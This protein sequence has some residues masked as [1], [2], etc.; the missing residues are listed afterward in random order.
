MK[1]LAVLAFAVTIPLS[2]AGAAS[3][4]TTITWVAGKDP[5]STNLP[6]LEGAHWILSPAQGIT[7]ATLTF[8]G[9][10]YDMVQ[11]GDGSFF[12]DTPGPVEDGDVVT[13]TF[14]GDND[15]AFL[16]LSHCTTVGS[17]SPSPSESESPS[18]SES[19]SPS[20]SDSESP[21]PSESESPSES[22]GPS[23]SESPKPSTSVKGESH[24]RTPSGSGGAGPS[25]TGGTAFTGSNSVPYTVAAIVLVLLGLAS[26]AIARRHAARSES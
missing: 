26:L 16:K 23:E 20:P 6:C 12:V 18:P 19:E 15:N 10:T 9:H 1:R 5:G 3:A 14:Q 17:P 4:S 2:I 24:T 25:D 11:S 13:V 8:D 7:S 22:V 21:S